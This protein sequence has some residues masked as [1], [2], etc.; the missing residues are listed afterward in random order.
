M[1]SRNQL[2]NKSITQWMQDR[3]TELKKIIAP[4]DYASNKLIIKRQASLEPEQKGRAK[5]L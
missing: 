1:P 2:G 3:E 4:T 5:N